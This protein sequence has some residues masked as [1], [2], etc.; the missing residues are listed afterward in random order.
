ML[1]TRGVYLAPWNAAEFLP[2]SRVF[3]FTKTQVPTF[4]ALGDT[5][6]PVL[7]SV[8]AVSAKIAASFVFIYAF[9]R[10]GGDPFLGLALSTSLAAW[11]NFG[12]LAVGLR[13]HL[14]SLAGQRVVT[15]YLKM[16]LVSVV[17]GGAC[18]LLHDWLESGWPG[19]GLTGEIVRLAIAI[20]AGVGLLLVGVAV[21]RVPEG[22]LLL[23][24]LRRR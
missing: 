12:W 24:F 19:G 7:G 5:R 4:Y 6:T 15:T 9:R 13:R 8:T 10:L 18:R 14:G 16:L 3:L 2:S 23:S 17:M 22:R 11:I 1:C 21:A 20:V